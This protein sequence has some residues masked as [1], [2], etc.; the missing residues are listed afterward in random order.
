VHADPPLFRRILSA[1][2]KGAEAFRD[3]LVKTDMDPDDAYDAAVVAINKMEHAPRVRVDKRAREAASEFIRSLRWRK[4][5]V[6]D[7]GPAP[8]GGVG[9]SWEFA[10]PEGVLEIDAVV[11]DWCRVEY[12]EG[13]AERE[14]FLEESKLD[15]T[16]LR[17]R[18][19]RAMAQHAA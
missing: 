15:E 7:V 5:P 9:M 17:E 6:P 2:R 1:V 11:L 8:D 18:L 14:G 12:R 19:L 10:T 16:Q 3:E 4:I 13:F